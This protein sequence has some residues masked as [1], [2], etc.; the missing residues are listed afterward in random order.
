MVTVGNGIS[1]I[2]VDCSSNDTIT[3]ELSHLFHAFRMNVP[4]RINDIAKAVDHQSL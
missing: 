4:H 2:G 3:G 1:H